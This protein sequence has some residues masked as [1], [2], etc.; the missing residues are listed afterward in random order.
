ME[1]GSYV[2]LAVSDNGAGMDEA[3]IARIFEPF[4][5]TKELGKGTGLGL[6]MVY[7]IVKQSNGH[8]W[9][10]SEPGVGTTVKIYLPQVDE[11]VEPVPRRPESAPARGGETV[12]LAEDEESL[13]EMIKE[14]LEERGYTVLAPGAGPPAAG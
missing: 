14:I 11:A 2:R 12:L 8:V 5:T 6:A 7:G 13:A 3:T 9:V 10:Y 4:F 1:P